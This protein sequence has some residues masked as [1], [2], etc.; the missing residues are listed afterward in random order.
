MKRRRLRPV[1]G[2]PVSP[3]RFAFINTEAQPASFFLDKAAEGGRNGHLPFKPSAD[4][5]PEIANAP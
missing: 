5:K 1:D 3:R 2:N 4:T